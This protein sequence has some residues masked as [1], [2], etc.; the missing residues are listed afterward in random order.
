[1]HYLIQKE[2]DHTRRKYLL[3]LYIED[4]RATLFRQTMFAEFERSTHQAVEEGEVLT[5]EW[6]CDYYLELNRKYFG[7]E[8]VYDPQI[9][10]EWSRIPHFYNAFYVYKY[11]TGYSAAVALSDKI[12]KEGKN[13]RDAYLNFLKSG[14]SDYPIALLQKAGVDM[15]QTEPIEKAMDT[16]EELIGELEKTI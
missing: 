5:A 10:M 11:A 2:V 1:M 6:L 13:A 7:D 12:L 9:A 4:F 14:D 8:V 16:F 3:N 15:S